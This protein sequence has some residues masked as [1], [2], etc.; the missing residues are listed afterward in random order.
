MSED[1]ELRNDSFNLSDLEKVEPPKCP[2]LLKSGGPILDVLDV[3]D[4]GW[5][6]CQWDRFVD[7]VKTVTTGAFKAVCLYRLV[8]FVL[9]QNADDHPATEENAA[10]SET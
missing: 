10:T 4:E 2:A 5:A 1:Y 7:G 9:A 6:H 3:D 8:P